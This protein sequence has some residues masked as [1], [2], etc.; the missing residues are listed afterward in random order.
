[1]RDRLAGNTALLE[2]AKE[3]VASE[4]ARAQQ[5]QV[6]AGAF[7]AIYSILGRQTVANTGEP[8]RVQIDESDFPTTL[9]AR[10]VPR[11]DQRAFVYA[12]I[13][14]PRATPWLP[15]QVSL[16]RDATF[17]GNGRLP[18]LAP[19]Q[20]HEI[21]FGPDDRIRVRTA[22][23]EDKR[24][25]SGIIASQRTENRNFRHIIKNLHEQP[26]LLVVH[27]Q[28]PVAGNQEIKVELLAKP[29]P[30]KRDVEDKR[31]VLAWEDKLAPDEEKTFE[32]G[33]RMSWPAAKSVV[34][35]R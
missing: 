35:G 3:D 20:E 10:T 31:G 34:Y 8:K 14:V 16:F 21:G 6:E 17:V 33:Y 32:V 24:G 25:E 13:T 5:A 2:K 9:V 18:Q 7:Q 1:M 19:G 30:T 29:Q 11:V 27:D 15:G 12:K 28:V 26:I 23:I 4:D 22:T